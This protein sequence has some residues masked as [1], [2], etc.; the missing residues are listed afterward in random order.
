M[1]LPG[2]LGIG[3]LEKSPGVMAQIKTIGV[4][5]IVTPQPNTNRRYKR[6]ENGGFLDM[7]EKKKW[8]NPID[9]A[10]NDPKSLR[11]AINAN[12][13]EC[14]GSDRTEVSKCTVK[15]CSFYEVRPW[16]ER[17]RASA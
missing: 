11:K 4:S 13:Y 7:S 14:S 15:N 17:E 2:W 9:V 1:S 3:F 16:A 10:K 12:C 8:P 5:R 6:R